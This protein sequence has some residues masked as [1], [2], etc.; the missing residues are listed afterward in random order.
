MTEFKGCLK[1]KAGY[2]ATPVARGWAGVIFE[3]TKAFGQ[4]QWCQ[5][6]QIKK[7]SVMDWPT[8]GWM[9]G[10]TKQGPESRSKL[11]V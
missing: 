5:K 8:N 1:N 7:L 2:T 11:S 6:L 3:V 9:D 4:E 10:R